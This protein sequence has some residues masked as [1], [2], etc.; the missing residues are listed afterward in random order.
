MRN[1][2]WTKINNQTK[3]MCVWLWCREQSPPAI[4]FVYCV[5]ILFRGFGFSSESTVMS[6]GWAIFFFFCNQLL[7]VAV[8]Y[9]LLG[10]VKVSVCERHHIQPLTCNGWQKLQV[11]CMCVLSMRTC[12][13]CGPG[14]KFEYFLV[15]D[16]IIFSLFSRAIWQTITELTFC[17]Q[18]QWHLTFVGL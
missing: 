5:S 6:N 18:I 13:G 8:V 12:D 17:I 16:R 1:N 10:S 11:A 4:H 2:R 15:C 9:I 14:W 7:Y 3:I